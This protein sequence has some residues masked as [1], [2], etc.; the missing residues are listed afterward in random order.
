LNYGALVE[1]IVQFLCHHNIGVLKLSQAPNHDA[2]LK[3]LSHHAIEALHVFL[4][5]LRHRVVEISANLGITNHFAILKKGLYTI[6]YL[7]GHL[8]YS[9][10][11]LKEKA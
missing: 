4:G 3:V 10:H 5:K 7:Q 2:L 8:K 11:I 1:D 9:F 6:G